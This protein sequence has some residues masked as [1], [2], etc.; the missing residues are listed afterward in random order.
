MGFLTINQEKSWNSQGNLIDVLGMNHVE[1][2]IGQI[3]VNYYSVLK[4]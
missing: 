1:A 2:T 4:Y 3:F